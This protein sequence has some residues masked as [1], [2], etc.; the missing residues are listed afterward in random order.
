MV[1]IHG[2]NASRLGLGRLLVE[3]SPDED[4]ENK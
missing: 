3:A 4:Y 1:V 2:S